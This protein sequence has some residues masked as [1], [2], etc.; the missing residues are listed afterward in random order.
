MSDPITV[1][2]DR[3]SLR[4]THIFDGEEVVTGGDDGQVWVATFSSG[5][6]AE[7]FIKYIRGTVWGERR[8]P[9]STAPKEGDAL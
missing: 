6:V 8:R 1:E 2:V 5:A 7:R 3:R 4:V 9:N